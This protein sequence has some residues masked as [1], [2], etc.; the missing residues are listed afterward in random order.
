M[1]YEDFEKYRRSSIIIAKSYR[2]DHS[3]DIQT[4]VSVGA[5]SRW[6][7][8]G[9]LDNLHGFFAAS[10][11][12]RFKAEGD[13]ELSSGFVRAALRVFMFQVLGREQAYA[14]MGTA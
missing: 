4:V 9:I 12:K 13:I 2:S 11:P 5:K 3:Q 7:D 6:C 8:G 1:C 10:V 14:K